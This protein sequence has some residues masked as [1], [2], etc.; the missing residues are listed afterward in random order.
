MIVVS[1]F[2]THAYSSQFI[3]L[4][5]MFRHSLAIIR[6]EYT[7]EVN[8]HRDATIQMCGSV[9]NRQWVLVSTVTNF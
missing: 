4:N 8:A 2:H 1:H 6:S 9:N 7:L 3:L 5:Y